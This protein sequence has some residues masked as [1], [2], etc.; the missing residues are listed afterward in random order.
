MTIR[1]I[2]LA[3]FALG[4]AACGAPSDET[5]PP[6]GQDAMA[7]HDTHDGSIE[8]SQ[9]LTDDGA[10]PVVD[11][12]LAWMRPHPEGRDVTAAYVVVRLEE[13]AADRLLAARIDGASEVELH[14]HMMD[15]QGMM[16]MRPIGPQDVTAGEP[17]VF[18]PGGRHLMVFG[19]APVSEGDAVDGVLVFERA[20][21][22]PVS[23][24]VR[25]APPGLPADE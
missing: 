5:A 24:Q 14:G 22:V 12:Q 2:A 8:T 6:A 18:I 23:F 20:G 16:Q 3:L 25:S 4:L 13:G 17:L 11:V 21:D 15:E 19:L 10:M 1:L 7:G 9:P